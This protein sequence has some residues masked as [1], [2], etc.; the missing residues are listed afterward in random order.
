AAQQGAARA[1]ARRMLDRP[2]L[3]ALGKRLP[4]QAFPGSVIARRSQA[5]DEMGY[6]EAPQARQNIVAAGNVHA[7]DSASPGAAIAV[8]DAPQPQS[9]SVQ[10]TVD[11]HAGMTPPAE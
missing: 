2:G 10:K 8:Q 3:Q 7:E 9:R 5:D 1:Q 11:Q 6:A 4:I